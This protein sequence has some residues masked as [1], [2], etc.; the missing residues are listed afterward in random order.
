MYPDVIGLKDGIIDKLQRNEN[1]ILLL[2]MD[3]T[4]FISKFRKIKLYFK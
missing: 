2:F 1:D 3:T 4:V